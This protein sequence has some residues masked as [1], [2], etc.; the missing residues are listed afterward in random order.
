MAEDI[1]NPNIEDD[2]E[3]IVETQSKLKNFKTDIINNLNRLGEK[4]HNTEK[5]KNCD[6]YKNDMQEILN[7]LNEQGGGTTPETKSSY[8]TQNEYLVL[9][10]NALKTQI[11]ELERLSKRKDNEIKKNADK[12]NEC[13]HDKLS[14]I[15]TNNLNI[16]KLSKIKNL[17]Y[18]ILEEIQNRIETMLNLPP[19]PG[20]SINKTYNK[21]VADFLKNF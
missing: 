1:K 18:G 19:Q 5:C 2:N 7:L 21:H 16:K 6:K 9:Q 13:E 12:I 10:N 11:S 3:D 8:K 4:I 15:N 14:S 20:G 17:S